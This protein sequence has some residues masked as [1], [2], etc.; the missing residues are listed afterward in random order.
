MSEQKQTLSTCCL[1]YPL[2]E[3]PTWTT[4]YLGYNPTETADELLTRI[5]DLTHQKSLENLVVTSNA[6]LLINGKYAWGNMLVGNLT[7]IEIQVVDKPESTIKPEE[8]YDS[9]ALK[10]SYQNV[11]SQKPQ[12]NTNGSPQDTLAVQM[13]NNALAYINSNNAE[14]IFAELNQEALQGLQN[15]KN[16]EGFIV[17]KQYQSSMSNT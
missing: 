16:V 15:L 3:T 9:E 11:I 10:S 8:V 1:S 6:R 2:Y 7:N 12:P 4:R 17:K 14:K 13:L 5:K